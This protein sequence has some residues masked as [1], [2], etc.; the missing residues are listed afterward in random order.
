LPGSR[1]RPRARLELYAGSAAILVVGVGLFVLLRGKGPAE[2]STRLS[3][4]SASPSDQ[5]RDAVSA[6]PWRFREMLAA[7]ARDDGYVSVTVHVALAQAADGVPARFGDGAAPG[8]NLYW[9]ALFGVETHL[10]N[11]AGWR[12]VYTDSGDGAGVIRRVVAHR[13]SEATASWRALGVED[14][15]DVFVLANAWPAER[16]RDAMGGPIRDAF[17][18]RPLALSVDGVERAFGSASAISGYV[19][20]DGLAE[21]YWD[22]FAD[23]GP[24][25]PRPVGVFYVSAHSAT[26]LHRAVVEHGLYPVLFVREPI[27]PEAY[28][29]EGILDALLAGD[30]GDAFVSQA[31]RRYSE[32]QSAISRQ[33]AERMFFR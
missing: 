30:V 31:G 23:L 7:D 6:A 3:P 14:Q 17:G 1:N 8:H 19:G 11:A 24:K 29:V 9:G 18:D 33:R 32:Y 28:V 27:I 20:A 2:V 26:Y 13:R 15:F 10:L 12:R 5:L 21:D 4:L 25:A 22:V 16:I